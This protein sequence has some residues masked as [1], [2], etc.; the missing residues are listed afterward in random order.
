MTTVEVRGDKEAIKATEALSKED[1]K[2]KALGEFADD[3]RD[4]LEK[5][6]YPPPVPNQRYIRTYRLKYGYY[7]QKPRKMVRVIS[8]RA[9]SQGGLYGGYVVGQQQAYMHQ[10]RWYQALDIVEQGLPDLADKVGDEG[11]R[12]FEAA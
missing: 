4:A 6:P 5:E 2:D 1:W 8:N 10:G 11:I 7:V 12:I 3:R 9:A